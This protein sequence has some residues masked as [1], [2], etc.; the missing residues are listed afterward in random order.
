MSLA[1]SLAGGGGGAGGSGDF[2]GPASSTDNAVVRFDGTTGKLGQNSVV[3]I[4]DAGAVAGVTLLDVDNIRVDGNTISSTNANGNISLTPNGT[5]QVALPVGSATAPGATFTGTL[6]A[7]LTYINGAVVIADE[8]SQMAAFDA[9][10]TGVKLPNNGTYAWVGNTAPAS[11]VGDT[12]ISRVAAGIVA[13]GTGA[14]GSGD[15]AIQLAE[16]TAP[17]GAANAV[18]LYAQDNGSGKTQL[19]AIFGSGAAQQVAIEP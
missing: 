7:G 14:S 16:R 19:M 15:G 11:S 5:G 3:T 9:S 18:R 17:A 13:V 4:S 10:A 12:G 1:T 6:N 2:V 8:G